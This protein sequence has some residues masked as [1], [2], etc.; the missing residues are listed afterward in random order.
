MSAYHYCALFLSQLGYE[1]HQEDSWLASKKHPIYAV[2][3]GVTLPVYLDFEMPS[4]PR[5]V[6]DLFCKNAVEFLERSY[7]QITSESITSAYQEA[8]G[9]VRKFNHTERAKYAAVGVVAAVTGNRIIAGRV[10]DCGLALLR[11]GK[12]IF[13]TPEFWEHKAKTDRDG[14]GVINGLTDVMPFI[15]HYL[16]EF[17]PKDYLV[18]FSD[19]FEA[20]FGEKEFLQAFAGTNLRALRLRII[21]A[22]RQLNKKDQKKFGHERTLVAVRL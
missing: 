16:L 4:G 1:W 19:G 17:K 3:D 10:T 2:A 21:R 9:E 5:T 14:Y 13:K 15:D 18:L 8:V 22:D 6:A 20:H 7:P 11:D 12:P